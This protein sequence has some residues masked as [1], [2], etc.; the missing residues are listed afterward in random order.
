MDQ[1]EQLY[2]LY[3]KNNLITDKVTLK[4]WNT[5]SPRQQKE[6]YNIGK[7]KGL[8]QKVQLEQF[9]SL[10]EE[11]VKKK[12]DSD[13]S[14]Q[15]QQETM[16]SDTT[17]QEVDGSS[18]LPE[19]TVEVEDSLE[20]QVP[21]GGQGVE[22]EEI[23]VGTPTDVS[24]IESVEVP[25]VA[26]TPRYNPYRTPQDLQVKE[27][28]TAIERAFG[29]NFLTD[30][31]GDLY[32]SGA[33]GI[34][35]GA[36]LDE[37]LELFAKGQ[38]VTDQDIQ[39]FIQAQQSLQSR[40][41]SDEMKDFNRIYQSEGGSLWGF[42]KG[43]VANPSVVPQIFVS[44]TTQLL[45]ASTIGAG[46]AG[47]AAG[48]FV[49]PIIG[50]LGG[51][52]GA[53]G[54][55]LE[56][57][58]TFAELLQKEL[59]ERE[60]DFTTDNV[61]TVLEDE[62]A[63]SSIRYKAAGRGLAIGII[64][65]ATAR[66]A[67]SVGAKVYRGGPLTKTRKLGALGAGFGVEAVG[68]STGE[69]AGRLVAGQEMDVAEIGFEGIAGMATA[70]LSVGYG[71][72]KSP[73]YY[74]N[75][76]NGGEEMSQT[77]ASTMEDFVE[78]APDEDFAKAELT[79]KN[80]PE[81]EAK[82]K[83]RK[84]D[85]HEKA[86]IEGQ[87]KRAGV[88][89]QA[90]I[91]EILPLQKKL[92]ELAEDTGEASKLKRS[93]IKQQINDIIQRQDAV[94]EQSTDA[95]DGEVQ[96]TDVQEVDERGQTTEE[97]TREEQQITE[98]T[99][100][101][102]TEKTEIII[103][104]EENR[105][106]QL[107]ETLTEKQKRTLAMMRDKENPNQE[108]I[109]NYIKREATKNG[110]GQGL[111][112]KFKAEDVLANPE[113]KTENE[114]IAAMATA[115]GSFKSERTVE[116]YIEKAKKDS[117]AGVSYESYG[118]QDDLISVRRAYEKLVKAGLVEGKIGKIY[119][120][121]AEF[122]ADQDTD[123]TEKRP[124][125]KRQ[126]QP[127]RK[128]I[129]GSKKYEI[130][131]DAEGK[132]QVV[133][134]KTGRPVKDVNSIKSQAVRNALLQEGIDVNEGRTSEQI[135]KENN[136]NTDISE[137]NPEQADNIILE[138]ENVREVAE[139]IETEKKVANEKRQEEIEIDATNEFEG[140][141]L[142][143]Q[144]W[145]EFNDKEN[146]TPQ[147][148]R[149]FITKGK[150]EGFDTKIQ[151]VA[152]RTN[153]DYDLV[154]EKF[155][156]YAIN[157][158]T[159]PKIS[160]AKQ[161][162]TLKL[163]NLE[164]RF[165]EL[166]GLK[167]TQKNIE[168]VLAVDPD[169]ESLQD[170]RL[171][172][173]V[174]Q[175]EMLD[176]GGI[177]PVSKKGR[178]VPAKKIVEGTKKK[179][180]VTVDEAEALKD[181]IKLEG[182]AAK[183]A[184]RAAKKKEKID[185]NINK[186]RRT[187][188]KNI[189]GKIGAD[190]TLNILLERMLAVN[191]KIVPASVIDRY[192]SIVEM[193]GKRKG[194]LNLQDINKLKNEVAEINK[195]LDEEYSIAGELAERFE[196]FKR[197][198]FSVTEN[199]SYEAVLDKML[200]QGEITQDEKK[201]M[202][203][204]KNQIAPKE[205]VE[206]TPEAIQ[207]E[208][209]GAIK[210]IEKADNT[211][212]VPENLSSDQKG[213]VRNFRKLLRN[214]EVLMMMEP[215]ELKN[216]VGL[217]D[218][219]NNGYVPHLLQLYT[220]SMQAKLAAMEKASPSI[221]KGK[222]LPF[223]KM[224]ANFKNLF[225]KKGA[226]L[227]AI[228]RNPLAYI[229]Q[230][231]GD[232]KTKNLYEA[233]FEPT[234]K[235][236]SRYA[237]ATKEI[238]NKLNKAKNDVFKSFG[239]DPNKTT[240]SAYKQQLY[241]LQREFESNPDNKFVNPAID[242][243]KATIKAI[244]EQKTNLTE[245]DAAALQ[246]ILE[247]FQ[248]EDGK[249]ID[250]EKLFNSFNDAEKASIKTVDEINAANEPAAVFTAST[251]R[252]NSFNALNNYVHHNVLFTA[253]AD[254]DATA[255]DFVGNYMK[256]LK[257]STKG[258]SLIKR[259]GDVNPLN[260]DVYSSTRKGAEY[261]ML[262]YH[263]TEPIRLARKTINETKKILEA[264]GRIPSEQREM[265]NALERAYEEVNKNVLTNDF[266]ETTL[267]DRAA[268]FMS[269]QGYRTVLAGTGRFVAELLSNIGMALFVDQDAFQNGMNYQ[270]FIFSDVGAK[271]MD[272]VGSAQK[273][274]VFAEGLAGRFV[275]PNVVERAEGGAG[276]Q[277]NSDIQN[278]VKQIWSFADQKWLGNVERIADYL[279]STPD[280]V[281]MRPMWF[282]SFAKEFKSITGQDVD[283]NKIAEGDQE[284]I[285]A[286]QE[287]IDAATQQADEVTTYIG[288][289]DNPYMGILK[290]TSKPNDSVSKKAFNNFNNFMTRF[291]IFEFV[292]AR[293][294]LQAITGNES[295]LTQEQGAKILAGVTTRMVTYSLLSSMLGAGLLGLFFEDD[296]EDKSLEKQFGQALGQTFTSLLIGRD[297]GNAVK[298]ILN[299]GVEKFNESH[300]EF[301][302]DGEYDPYKDS[303]QYSVLPKKQQGQGITMGDLLLRFGGSFGPAL[304]T[305]DL[306]VRKVSEPAR[307]T[308]EARER[309]LNEQLIRMP[310]EVAGNLGLI[311]I[312]KDVRKVAIQE[313]YKD[314][315]KAK[316]S[317]FKKRSKE[318]L[319]KIKKTNP[320]LYKQ[321]MQNNP[322][323]S[324]TNKKKSEYDT[325]IRNPRL[326]KQKNPGK[327]IP[328]RP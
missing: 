54:A 188:R 302:R 30:F 67:S 227:E 262:D 23:E 185:S 51:A 139:A 18:A 276:N 257:P 129:K 285:Q 76:K 295:R 280:K 20:V 189:K 277:I 235:A 264:E 243:L 29:K 222:M 273:D 231:F 155:F 204:Y 261:V 292:T 123:V 133:E 260:F 31:F 286:N 32:R 142:T 201:L 130:E 174:Q 218:N 256:G 158:P 17:I 193:L 152:D 309:Q 244:D 108:M 170:I 196:Y 134:A 287:A 128:K 55:T 46:I 310:L 118:I 173:E 3:L 91:D 132:A 12:D 147:I 241:L 149:R 84:D 311:P 64:E 186:L 254:S 320:R 229:D 72:Y 1:K 21:E 172:D 304:S 250:N 16:E 135:F 294:A 217:L 167:A 93:E 83:K 324:K 59:E 307:K 60:L 198:D 140:V 322:E 314:L 206:K 259:T 69:V 97:S 19:Q 27:K 94:Q 266:G 279:I 121:V 215:Y 312:Y 212:K 159:L 4:M 96:A 28:D 156:E 89:D 47:G 263:M 209:E 65:G 88:T 33:A 61:R 125:T 283:F 90:K 252:G 102:E 228:R 34:A 105:L 267:A 319:E 161:A 177:A 203:K 297:F 160:R 184:D 224:Y 274:R 48:S 233:I 49:L 157:N 213:L 36:T 70:P 181:Q 104:P 63:L 115:D 98:T 7:N 22:V 298:A 178:G 265:I 300:L 168:A 239:N 317:K 220:T 5:M 24:E 112:S 57:G 99:E 305:A 175:K 308:P 306:I 50:T 41:E 237:T 232:F 258:Q 272:N 151:E 113:G 210:N 187:A 270:E 107:E 117:E 183:E 301:L 116:A 318:E 275:D 214:K 74:I 79:I 207:E 15:N 238:R 2:N 148:R 226:V 126:A 82:A 313:I 66:L 162:R 81:L 176:K 316:K 136:P 35:Q 146:L 269:R 164:A 40:G 38:N 75:K 225:T 86:V 150:V 323:V 247:K 208:K 240:L 71:I 255:P 124:E 182:K 165:E 25:T 192:Q 236:Q 101:T 119:K 127:E 205:R 114:L 284:Y 42:I 137:V 52:M 216:M 92:N 190:Q 145:S 234:A 249:S 143:E 326:W 45:N 110:K 166:T 282:G 242:V 315:R 290:G 202:E 288:A 95:V 291:L 10:W 328:K 6:I 11:P 299:I 278:K 73:K 144:E 268:D 230:I 169:R 197:I 87:L 303:L 253:D 9:T 138:S 200:E 296:E 325:Y 68:G 154:M 85:L 271:I 56:T 195:V 53:A 109:N 78:N 281:V 77:T 171:K 180:E 321:I 141:S 13:L 37:S 120:S 44:S 179:K 327:P 80:N 153:Q 106:S 26:E 293:S 103:T 199:T 289:A 131:L 122:M 111:T 194:T 251:I 43:V 246:D 221:K 39:E 245:K 219:V 223:T 211:T 248:T 62:E 191:P 58:I 163:N 8:F 100:E 14:G